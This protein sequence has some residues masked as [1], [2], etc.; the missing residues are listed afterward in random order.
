MFAV[1]RCFH[2]TLQ[3][4]EDNGALKVFWKVNPLHYEVADRQY[5]RSEKGDLA[6]PEESIAGPLSSHHL[7]EL[8]LCPRHDMEGDNNIPLNA[9][10]PS[11]TA[12]FVILK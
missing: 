6:S 1:S 10:H 4:D 7:Q 12:H 8:F 3:H 11:I 2:N 5:S 9:I